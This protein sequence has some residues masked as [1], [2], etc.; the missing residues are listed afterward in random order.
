M[1]F[2]VMSST[3]KH[4]TLAFV[5]GW[6]T[7]DFCESLSVMEIHVL[8]FQKKAMIRSYKFFGEHEFSILWKQLLLSRTMLHVLFVIM[9]KESHGSSW[10]SE[11]EVWYLFR[12][13]SSCNQDITLLRRF[14]ISFNPHLFHHFLVNLRSL[15]VPLTY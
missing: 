11:F 3:I 13:Q 9:E 10:N 12:L 1:W 4:V 14:F 8:M 2:F 7:E 15:P 6:S 5:V